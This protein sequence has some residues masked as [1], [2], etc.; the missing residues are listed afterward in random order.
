MR[1]PLTANYISLINVEQ[2]GD[3]FLLERTWSLG[4]SRNLSILSKLFIT[5]NYLGFYYWLRYL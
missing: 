5:L 1:K 3:V 4:L 2:L